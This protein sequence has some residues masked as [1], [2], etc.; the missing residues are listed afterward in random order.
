LKLSVALGRRPILICASFSSDRGGFF[1][2]QSHQI[3]PLI[4]RLLCGNER[5]YE[6]KKKEIPQQTIR[7]KI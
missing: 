7:R 6:T 5:K 2:K 3:A 1:E 4:A